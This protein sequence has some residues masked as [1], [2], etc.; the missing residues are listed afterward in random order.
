MKDTFYFSHDYNASQDESMR[1]LI[2]EEGMEGYGCYWRIIEMLYQ[3]TDR[4]KLSKDYKGISF[5]LRTHCDRI[6]N[7]IE[8]YELF[9]FDDEY[10]WSDSVLERVEKRNEKSEKAKDSARARW[11]RGK[12]SNANALRPECDRNAIKERKG[13]EIKGNKRKERDKEK[14]PSQ[15]SR[16]FFSKKEKQ[17]EL[18]FKISEEKRIPIENVNNEI[19]KFV[20]YW[21]EKNK[22]GTRELWETKPTFE[23]SRRLISWF[24]NVHTFSPPKKGLEVI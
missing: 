17:D 23:V 5:D 2:R 20:S 7:I 10:F 1:K 13:K 12:P 8:K 14:T 16:E 9:Q 3:E 4:Y 6:K 24:G 15:I 21:T 22:N 18:A 11:G 19:I